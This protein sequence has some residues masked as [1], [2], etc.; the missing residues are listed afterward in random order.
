M[1]MYEVK[2]VLVS[3]TASLTG[4][5]DP[6]YISMPDKYVTANATLPLQRSIYSHIKT[7]SCVVFPPTSQTALSSVV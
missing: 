5:A 7:I 4:L 1:I 6:R 2:A 3:F